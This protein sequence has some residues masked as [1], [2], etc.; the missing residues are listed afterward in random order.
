MDNDNNKNHEVDSKQLEVGSGEQNSSTPSQNEQFTPDEMAQM[1]GYQPERVQLIDREYMLERDSE[2]TEP[3]ENSENPLVRFAI[4]SM[5]VGG[6]LSA[7]WLIWSIFF[8]VKSPA[9]KIA[10]TPTPAVKPETPT[11]DEAARLKAE[12]AFRNQMGRQQ[13]ANVPAPTPTP[14]ATPTPTPTSTQVAASPA[15]PQ[16][17][18]PPKPI[19]E[20]APPPKIVYRDRV[21]REPAPPPKIVYRDRVVKEPAPPPQVLYRDRIVKEPAPPPQVVYRDRVVKEPAPPPKIVYRD[22]VVKEPAPPP[23]IIRETIPVSAQPHIAAAPSPEAKTPEVDPFERWNQLATVGQQATDAEVASVRSTETLPETSVAAL[24]NN[25]QLTQPNS[26]SKEQTKPTSIPTITIG[27]STLIPSAPTENSYPAEENKKIETT[28]QLASTEDVKSPSQEETDNPS[29]F[30][31][32][33]ASS[34]PASECPNNSSSS[35]ECTSES[36][37]SPTPGE[38]GILNRTPRS[39][40]NSEIAVAS[41]SPMQ[42][43]IGTS[44]KAKVLVPMIWSE[45]NQADR[46]RFAVQLESDV[47]STDNR[48]ALPK[49]TI[50]ITEVD[51]VTSDNKLV[52]Q[53]AVAVVYPDSAGEIRQQSIPKES[54]L[55]RGKNGEPLIAKGMGDKGGEIAR[56]DILIGLL[57][58]AGRAGE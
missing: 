25:Q 32:V 35:W 46:G 14:A 41:K 6:I 21:V 1:T 26:I 45:E 40:T 31:I 53:S 58:A 3:R 29:D 28:P 44:A 51:S 42:V 20:P 22:R 24:P 49:G 47:L 52:N 34:S 54:I 37:Q 50:L 13:Q 7:G 36:T 30:Q 33:T 19:A 23:K 5:L 10:A 15:K 17:S 4:A 55:I 57:G 12:L 39:E 18:P 56:Q 9:P 48:V 43:Q 11:N 8:A 27:D 38:L 2:T 16:Q